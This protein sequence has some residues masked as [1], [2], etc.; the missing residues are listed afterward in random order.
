VHFGF[1]L[2]FGAAEGGSEGVDFLDEVGVGDGVVEACDGGLLEI[3]F[4][5]EGLE[6]GPFVGE[7]R[8]E[9]G[10]GVCEDDG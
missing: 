1:E 2:V 6:F 3:Y 4:F 7:F 8:F 5:L 10:E 9:I